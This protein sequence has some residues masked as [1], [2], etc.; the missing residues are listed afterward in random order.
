ML[1]RSFD[2][3]RTLSLVYAVRFSLFVRK[4]SLLEV[5]HIP[6]K[7]FDLGMG[8]NGVHEHKKL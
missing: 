4:P 1:T 6:A 3:K 5:C 2:F 8:D 7:A